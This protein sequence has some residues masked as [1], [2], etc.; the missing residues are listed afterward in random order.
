MGFQTQSK[1]VYISV[2][3]LQNRYT[4]N[5]C[6]KNLLQ[7]RFRFIAQALAAGNDGKLYSAHCA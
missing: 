7:I 1:Y 5:Y 2:C 6:V 4:K 3:M